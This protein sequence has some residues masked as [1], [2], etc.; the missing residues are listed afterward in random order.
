MKR[1]ALILLLLLLAAPASAAPRVAVLYFDNVGNPELDM[2]RL[3]LAEMMIVDLSNRPDVAVVERNRINQV[4]GELDLQTTDKFDPG[5]AVEIGKLL[6]AERMVLGS[7]F[8]LLGTLTV[9]A[10]VV[11][12]AT[13]QSIGGHKVQGQI[14]EFSGLLEQVTAGV[15]P[16]L[17]QGR[18]WLDAPKE[19]SPTPEPPSGGVR[20]GGGGSASSPTRTA[21]RD[22]APRPDG[23]GEA[24]S[25]DEAAPA[26]M[27][28]AGPRD[29]LGAAMAFSEGL[30]YLDRK[31]LKRAR[32]ALQRAVDL[33]PGLDV[34]RTELARIHL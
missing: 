16:A 15:A 22:P 3:G 8:E 34:A 2:L 29:A 11:E 7:Y 5:K 17:V 10:S 18:A 27:A 31:D 20:G 19:P 21:D 26:A 13:G 4:L 6:G 24:E 30:D 12:V 28:D 33:D 32:D 25:V 9:T 14:A 23:A 1:F